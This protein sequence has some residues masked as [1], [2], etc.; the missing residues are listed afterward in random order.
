EGGTLGDQL[1]QGMTAADAIS[2]IVQLA[3]ALAAAHDIGI[4]HR[5]LKPHNIML[6]STGRLFCKVLDFGLAKPIEEDDMTLTQAGWLVGTPAYMA[7]E[8]LVDAKP[9]TTQ[10]DAWALAVIAYEAL[11]GQRPFLGQH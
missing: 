11:T 6:L 8:Q 5:D 4:V 7:P 3:G 1:R 9:A 10:T 2:V